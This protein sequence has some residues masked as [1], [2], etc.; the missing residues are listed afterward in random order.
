MAAPTDF[1]LPLQ[2]IT[3]IRNNHVRVRASS[4]INMCTMRNK[5]W[6]CTRPV[7]RI[8]CYN[9]SGCQRMAFQCCYM[10]ARNFATLGAPRNRL[11]AFSR[12]RRFRLQRRK[13]RA[14]IRLL[15]GRSPQLKVFPYDVWM[16]SLLSVGFGTCAA[17]ASCAGCKAHGRNHFGCG[18]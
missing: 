6:Q 16:D 5:R 17:R 18:M 9:G 8:R 14:W 7:K 11:F 2:S 1:G 12:I 15:S 10:I 13:L 4:V 3:H